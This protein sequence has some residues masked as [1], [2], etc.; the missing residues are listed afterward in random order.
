MHPSRKI[1]QAR[2]ADDWW[3]DHYA[4]AIFELTAVDGGT[5]PDFTQIGVPPH[6]YEGHCRGWQLAY[7]TPMKEL[8][9]QGS[10]S[11]ATRANIQAARQR[12]RMGKV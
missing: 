1:V 3:P 6:R 7:W 4:I 12:I 10:T 5:R 9:E 8:L 11:A 2:C